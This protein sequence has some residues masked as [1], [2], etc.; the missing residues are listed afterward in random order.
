[1]RATKR[2]VMEGLHVGLSPIGD[3]RTVAAVLSDAFLSVDDV[4]SG[5]QDLG[6]NTAG[7]MLDDD[8][9]REQ[10][11]WPRARVYRTWWK[12]VERFITY[13]AILREQERNVF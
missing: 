7:W 8:E 9:D 13:F 2:R 12:K 11:H 6:D 10:E 5:W 1:M 3:P 4:Q